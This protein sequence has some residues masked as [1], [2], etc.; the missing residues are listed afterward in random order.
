MEKLIGLTQKDITKTVF[1]CGDPKRVKEISFFMDAPEAVAEN[2]EYN[3]WH[4][5]SGGFPKLAQRPP[6]RSRIAMARV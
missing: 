5:T 1:I 6:F 4:S 2:R 3:S